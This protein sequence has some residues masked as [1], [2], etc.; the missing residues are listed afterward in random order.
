MVIEANEVMEF[1]AHS[2][3]TDEFMMLIHGEMMVSYLSEITEKKVKLTAGSLLLIPANT[4]HLVKFL[5]PSTIF[6]EIKAGPFNE[7]STI[8]AKAD[9]LS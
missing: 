7:N 5:A 2:H 8:F 3:P 6:Y 4:V 1:P 9:E